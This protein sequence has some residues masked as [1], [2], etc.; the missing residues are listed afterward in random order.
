MTTLHEG[1]FALMLSF[2]ESTKKMYLCSASKQKLINDL[3]KVGLMKFDDEDFVYNTE[4]G[5]SV[6]DQTILNFQGN[7]LQATT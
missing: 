2:R 4:L 6:I 7:V 5:D 3:I 1:H